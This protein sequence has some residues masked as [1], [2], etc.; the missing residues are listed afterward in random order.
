MAD[1]DELAKRFNEIV[2]RK[3]RERERGREINEQRRKSE[4]EKLKKR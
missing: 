1:P 3:N 2:D 4:A